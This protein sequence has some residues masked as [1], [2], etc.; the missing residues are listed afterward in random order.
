[1]RKDL[2][3]IYQTLSK[4]RN[5]NQDTQS[6]LEQMRTIQDEVFSENPMGEYVLPTPVET[7]EIATPEPT[8]SKKKKDKKNNKQFK[9]DSK[10]KE[11]V[12]SKQKEKVDLGKVSDPG[13]GAEVKVNTP[14][15]FFSSGLGGL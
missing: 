9:V 3:G 10:Q 13:K 4:V 14:T 11:K 1:M 8:S 15:S 7:A 6:K 12:D 2:G 5:I